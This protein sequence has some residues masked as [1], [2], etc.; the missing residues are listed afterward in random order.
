MKA[1]LTLLLSLP[2]FAS[3]QDDITGIWLGYIKTPGSQLEFEIGITDMGNKFLGYSLINYPKDGADNIGVKTAKVKRGK[4]EIV[5][6]DDELIFENF[7]VTPIR[8]KMV[9]QLML[10]VKDTTS[11]LY[12]TFKTR[13]IDFRDTRT[14]NGEIYLKKFP[15]LV[16]TKIMTKLYELNLINTLSFINSKDKKQV[17]E[18]ALPFLVRTPINERKVETIREIVYNSDSLTINVVDNG[19]VDGDTISLV[20]NGK[21]IAEKKGLTTK[22]FKITIPAKATG[23]S[24]LLI[25]H[26]ESLGTIPPNTGLLIIEDGPNRYEIRFSGDLQR[27][28]AVLL[29]RK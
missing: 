3:S 6:E 5:I 8:M 14:Y 29:R 24:M 23:D 27:S 26:A 12:G 19:T 9:C 18:I 28:S 7:T 13:A 22:A 16:P 4:R 17:P 20:L 15:K 11:I 21:L 1:I 2:L 25:M 10:Q